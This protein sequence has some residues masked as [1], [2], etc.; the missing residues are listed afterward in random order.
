MYF[1][2]MGEWN[3]LNKLFKLGG[4]HFNPPNRKLV[5]KRVESHC[6]EVNT[7]GIFACNFSMFFMDSQRDSFQKIA[8]RI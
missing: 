1:V 8:N 5:L 6:C 2:L 7:F 4:K 3:P